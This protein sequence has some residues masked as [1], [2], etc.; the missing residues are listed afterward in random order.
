MECQV[1]GCPFAA[2]WATSPI[3]QWNEMQYHLDNEHFAHRKKGNM[4]TITMRQWLVL[5]EY[6]RFI[7]EH[8]DQQSEEVTTAKH[9]ARGFAECLAMS[10]DKPLEYPDT[11]AV[12]KHVKAR[13]NA[14]KAGE[15][16]P[17]TTGFLFSGKQMIDLAGDLGYAYGADY[18]K[19]EKELA[20]AASRPKS[21][22]GPKKKVKF[23]DQ[24]QSS[25]IKA[26]NGGMEPDELASLY[27]CSPEDIEALRQ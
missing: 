7:M 1:P 10:L 5:D 26:L 11:N 21:T 3:D 9:R 17:G 6:M 20:D 4:A 16:L 15:I 25:I 13:Y 14:Y 27:G 22:D 19:L 24:Q 23:T 2:N 12:I 8:P 18:E